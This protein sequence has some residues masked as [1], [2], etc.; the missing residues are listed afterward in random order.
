[1]FFYRINFLFFIAVLKYVGLPCRKRWCY[2][3]TDFGVILDIQC[4]SPTAEVKSWTQCW[5]SPE[6]GLS[7]EVRRRP[8][9][10]GG[11]SQVPLS[12]PHVLHYSPPSLLSPC[13]RKQLASVIRCCTYFHHFISLALF[14]C[15]SIVTKSLVSFCHA[16]VNQS[17]IACRC[18]EL[19]REKGGERDW[20]GPNVYHCGELD[21]RCWDNEKNKQ[22]IM[23]K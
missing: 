11:Y 17:F 19:E 15:F 4:I 10:Q 6:R 9:A 23:Q 2:I 1:M 18:K 8:K 20:E 12:L 16:A 7:S 13:T 5:P 14:V 21:S 22:T 3:A